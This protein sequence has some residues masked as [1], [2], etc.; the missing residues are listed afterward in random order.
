M[1]FLILVCSLFGVCGFIQAQDLRINGRVIDSLGQPIPGASVVIVGQSSGTQTGSDGTFAMTTQVNSTLEVSAIG[2]AKQSQKVVAGVTNYIFKLSVIY[3]PLDEVVVTAGG[4]QRRKREEGYAATR[5][6]A[7]SI[8]QAKA[9]NVAASLSGK[10]AGLQVNAINGGVNPTVKMVLR[11]NR[12]LLGNNEALVVLDNVIVPANILGNLNPEDIED[13]NVL[14][15]AG[16]AALYGSEASNGAIIITTKRGSKGQDVVKISHTATVE[17]VSFYPKLQT[18][19]GS[20]TDTG[21]FLEYENQQYGPRFDGSIKQLGRADLDG[22]KQE[23]VYSPNSSREDFWQNGL[24]NQTDFSIASN[25]AVGSSYLSVQWATVTGTTPRDEFNR[26][27]IRYNGSR[28]L[29]SKFSMNF[30][31]NYIQ[32]RYD[33][34]TQ[35]ATIYA[36][37]LNTPA[38][39]PLTSFQDWK[40][41]KWSTPE[42][43]YN[44]YYMNPYFYVDNYRQKSRNDYLTG[45]FDINWKPAKGLDVLFRTGLSTRNQSSKSTTG[46]YNFKNGYLRGGKQNFRVAGAASDAMSY[47]TQITSDLMVTYK[48]RVSDFDFEVMGGGHIRNNVGKSMGVGT[49]NGLI[50]PD[51]YNVGNSVS[52]Q[53]SASESNNTTR[54][55]GLY[56]KFKAGYKNYL[57]LD[58]TARNDWRSVLNPDNWSFFYPAVNLS[59]VAS[60]AIPALQNS[61]VIDMLKLRAG[62]SQV[63]NVNLSAYQLMT[64]YSQSNG[65]PYAVAGPGFS[66]GGTLVNPNLK[67]EIS[68]SIEAGF[69]ADLLDRRVNVGFSWYYTLTSNQTVSP[70]ISRA[71]GYS[72]Y[73]QNTGAVTNTGVEVMA[74]WTPI[75]TKDLSVTIGGNYTYLDNKVKEMAADL[76]NLALSSGGQV[77]SYA[78]E[79]MPFPV[80]RGTDYLRDPEGRVIVDAITG[81]PVGREDGVIFGNSNPKHRTGLDLEVRYKG[82]RLWALAEYRGGF[83]VFHNGGTDMD[84]SGSSSRTTMYNRER[85]VFPNS[86]VEV[87]PGK[88]IANKTIQV[89]DGGGGFWADNDGGYNRAVGSNYIT[90][91]DYWKVREI[92]L[93]YDIPKSYLNKMKFVKAATISVQGRNLFLFTPES[94]IYTDPEYNFSDGNAIGI[95]TLGQTPPSRYFGGT[96]SLSF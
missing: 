36:N 58:I 88:F 87:E 31:V 66:V 82:F 81:Y 45:S 72:A 76:K 35:T 92:S 67:P 32:N 26:A 70:G 95:T 61:K 59:Y 38:W 54:Q 7:E 28:K 91:G 46:V 41:D 37:L 65:F 33:I 14:N 40:N 21:I 55:V 86:S 52:A 48:K 1:K 60:D 73:R 83:Y 84:F 29:G 64:T 24:T 23:Y 3:N 44:D 49:A 9:V 12:S 11:G 80:L 20:G 4:I 53:R 17:K 8:T 50:V 13:I 96:I 19:F 16:A 51:L 89:R 69:D 78:I 15:G 85:F 57:F 94:N 34:T 25:S 79:G 18:E 90:K 71:T 43:Y 22:S 74:H 10:V 68:E 42:L 27:S 6:T 63:G 39:A 47:T 75:R 56:G 62:W 77:Q 2:F 30:A 5:V 93:S